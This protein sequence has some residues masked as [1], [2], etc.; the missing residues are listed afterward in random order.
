[1]RNRL[2]M[3]TVLMLI[4]GSFGTIVSSVMVVPAWRA[5]HGHGRVGTYTLTEPMSCDR[6]PP[7]HHRCGW[8]G[9]FVS[10]DHTVIKRHRELAGGL[11]PGAKV[12]DTIRARDAGSSNEIYVDGDAGGWHN[13]ALFLAI[14][15][16]LLVIGVILTLLLRRRPGVPQVRGASST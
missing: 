15:S 12:G 6:E 10:D 11:P 14:S 16:A 9:D 5:A 2:T 8:F 13:P 3:V 4:F 7:P 1:V